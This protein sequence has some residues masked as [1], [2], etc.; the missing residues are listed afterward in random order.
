MRGPTARREFGFVLAVAVA[1]LALV[2]VV[3]FAPWY[4]SPAG[5]YPD[6]SPTVWQQVSALFGATEG[7]TTPTP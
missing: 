2:L 1:G 4:P 7:N 5:S 3:A 6:V